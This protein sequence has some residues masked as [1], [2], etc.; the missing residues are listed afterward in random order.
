MMSEPFLWWRIVVFDGGDCF[1]RWLRVF[2]G[3]LPDAG[4][5][6]VC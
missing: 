5:V 6:A 3:E 1:P 4:S 2:D